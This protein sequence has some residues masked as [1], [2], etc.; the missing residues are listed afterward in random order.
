MYK[1][2]KQ[3]DLGLDMLSY[4]LTE[5][6]MTYQLHE[7]LPSSSKI[8]MPK[9]H[10]SDFRKKKNSVHFMIINVL[11]NSMHGQVVPRHSSNQEKHLKEVILLCLRKV[12]FWRIKKT[13]SFISDIWGSFF[14][15]IFLRAYTN[16]IL[17]VFSAQSYQVIN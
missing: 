14:V 2:P 1:F 13:H 3:L 6:T 8:M 15:S 9:S 11:D 17:D 10:R 16:K 5:M 4:I 7:N 12:L